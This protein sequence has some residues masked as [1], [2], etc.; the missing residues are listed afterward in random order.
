MFQLLQPICGSAAL[1][2]AASGARPGLF[3]EQL[4]LASRH[5]YSG[6]LQFFPSAASDADDDDVR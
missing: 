6:R 3:D 5:A 2:V 4:S 1:S